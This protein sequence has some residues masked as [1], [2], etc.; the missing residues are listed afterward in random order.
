MADNEELDPTPPQGISNV[1]AAGYVSSRSSSDSDKYKS[2]WI[3]A[4][5][6][7]SSNLFSGGF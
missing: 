2:A 6:I 1:F 7:R 5:V 3:N 4:K